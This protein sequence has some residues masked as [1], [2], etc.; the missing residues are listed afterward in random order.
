MKC[1][2]CE[3]TKRWCFHDCECAKCIDR[4]GYDIWKNDNPEEYQ[5]LLDRQKYDPN[6]DY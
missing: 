4:E 5:D 2:S 1:W 6:N 3:S